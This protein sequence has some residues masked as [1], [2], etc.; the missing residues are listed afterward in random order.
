VS[1]ITEAFIREINAVLGI[2]TKLSRSG[3]YELVEG[4]TERL[5]SICRQ[6]GATD[7]YSGPAAKAYLD[8]SLFQA[9]GVNV[10][11]FDYGGYHPYS[12]LHGTFEHG[13]S[14]LDLIFNEGNEAIR[15]MKNFS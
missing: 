7:Y 1:E 2:Q 13:V 5:V 4:K 8:E 14:V 9:A 11:Y 6:A 3:D 10:H 15:Y 12:Q